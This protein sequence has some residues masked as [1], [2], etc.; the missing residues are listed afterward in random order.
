MVVLIY[1][2]MQFLREMLAEAL[3]GVSSIA[4]ANELSSEAVSAIGLEVIPSLMVVDAR[5]PEAFA[6]VFEARTRF[7]ALAV[8]VLA[9]SDQEAEFLAWAQIGISGYVEPQ[10]SCSQLTST[11]CRAAIGEV[12]CSRRLTAALLK[13][14]APFPNAQPAIGG[15]FELTSR[16]REVVEQLATGLCNK[17]IARKLHIAAS[18]VKNHVHSIL[19]K[20]EVRT[21]GEAAARYW[22][23]TA[24]WCTEVAG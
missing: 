17:R 1:S 22:Q 9:R 13:R 5:H 23:S 19:E 18:T 24:R 16:E 6:Q 10:T 3:P 15:I 11:I 12:V 21:R 7:P 8:V 2:Q 4:V 20:W 14:S